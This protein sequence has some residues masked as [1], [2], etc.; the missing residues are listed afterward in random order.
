MRRAGAVTI[1]VLLVLS[2]GGAAAQ[3]EKP[4]HEV[5]R[6]RWVNVFWN[7]KIKVDSDT[8]LRVTW[9]AGAYTSAESGFFSDLYRSVER[10]TR[11]DGHLRCRYVRHMSWYGYTTREAGNSFTLD[12]KLTSAHL[13]AAYRLYR[14]AHGDAVLVGRFRVDTEVSGTGKLTRGRSSY[15]SHQGCTTYRS[16]GKWES[17]QGTATGTLAEGTGATVDLGETNDANFGAS[18]N[19]EIEHTC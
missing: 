19:L 5:Y 4:Q 15:S 12:Q 10:C 9:Y 7:S 18:Q 2:I 8:S 14:R 11:S 3:A 1:G 13:D 6:N 17:R 16:S